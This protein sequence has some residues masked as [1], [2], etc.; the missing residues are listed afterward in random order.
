MLARIGRTRMLEEQCECWEPVG[1]AGSGRDEEIGWSSG[2]V[3]GGDIG[4]TGSGARPE[5]EA[6][7]EW[8]GLEVDGLVS[9]P[10]VQATTVEGPAQSACITFDKDNPVESAP[11]AEES[12][13]LD[14]GN[15]W[16]VPDPTV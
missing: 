15:F 12:G 11:A 2:R 3:G 14:S 10:S 6:W 8:Y 1:G 9:G 4:G 5:D 16:P 13:P 7:P